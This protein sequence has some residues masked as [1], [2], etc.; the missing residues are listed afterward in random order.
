MESE[1]DIQRRDGG[2]TCESS[3][4]LAEP[5]TLKRQLTGW[6]EDERPGPALGG[7]RLQLFKHRDEEGRCLPGARPSHRHNILNVG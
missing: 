4:I 6:A 3:Q 7:P 5:D 1:H 2:L